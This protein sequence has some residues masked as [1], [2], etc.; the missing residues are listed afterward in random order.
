MRDYVAVVVKRLQATPGMV[1]AAIVAATMSTV[2]VMA[3]LANSAIR[4]DEPYLQ[5]LHVSRPTSVSAGG[6][7]SYVRV[8]VDNAGTAT[9][10]GCYAKAYNHRLFS[11]EIDEFSP[12]GRS[13]QFNLSPYGG[14]VAT[15]S[16]YLPKI[17]GEAL[18]GGG[19][20][21]PV[22]FRVECENAESSDDSK[23]VVVPS[24]V[25]GSEAF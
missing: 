8:A 19:V 7:Y 16:V 5:M 21:A 18:L 15:V 22:S 9:A 20:R 4:P 11:N 3:G 14:Y 25:S 17:S 1:V 6:T 13:E 12:L 10:H 24:A 2:V 23:I